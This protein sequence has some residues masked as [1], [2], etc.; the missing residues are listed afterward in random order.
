MTEATLSSIKVID[1]DTHILEPPDL[2]TSR[3]SSR[4]G[5][6][7]PHI[8]RYQPQ[9]GDEEEYWFVANRPVFAGGRAAQLNWPEYC[10]EHP[11]TFAEADPACWDAATR[12]KWMDQS[13]VYAQVLYSNV[14][15]FSARELLES[16][17]PE[18]TY[19]VIRAYNDFQTDWSSVAP[20]RLLPMTQ[21][22]FWNL[23]WTITE[24]KRCAEN[25]HRGIVFSQEP[26]N[27]GLPALADPHWY[28]LWATAQ[29]M[30]L[31]VNFHIA[32]G[33][34][35]LLLD[36]GGW[37]G[38]GKHANFSWAGVM[39]M[40]GNLRTISQLIIGGV[41]HRFPALN[42]VSV[43]SGI[44]WLPFALEA[45]DWQWRNCGVPQEHP[46]YD[47]LPSEYFKRQIYGCFWFEGPSALAAIE[48]LGADNIMFETDFP[49]ATSMTPGPASAAQMPNDYIAQ[50]FVTLPETTVR[51]ILHDNAARIYALA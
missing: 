30:G 11:H 29:E 25:G 50:T 22:P 2:W 47:L 3:M 9:G 37:A 33:D 19:E 13:G 41:C 27:F 15:M 1:T 14:A 28:P 46:E 10:P 36:N 7:V 32:S 12:L 39:M 40:M 5:D 48:Q 4:W 18:F 17:D 34:N 6:D 42:F 31:P 8:A 23:D 24:I 45:L 26:A 35:S 44:G 20:D 38:A 16:T 21:V 49:H 51:K 43:E